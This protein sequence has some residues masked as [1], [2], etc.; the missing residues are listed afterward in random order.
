MQKCVF[1]AAELALEA[2]QVRVAHRL[3]RLLGAL[4]QRRKPLAGHALQQVQ[5]P[6]QQRQK[7]LREDTRSQRRNEALAAAGC[8]CQINPPR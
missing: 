1:E 3:G 5:R 7:D 6:V 2:T 4:L 8:R